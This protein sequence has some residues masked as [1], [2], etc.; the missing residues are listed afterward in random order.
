MDTLRFLTNMDDEYTNEVDDED[1]NME[2]NDDVVDEEEDVNIGIN[3][4]NSFL[5]GNNGNY[6]SDDNCDK[7]T[8]GNNL[9]NIHEQDFVSA[10]LHRK[11]PCR[12]VILSLFC[13]VLLKQ[14][15]DSKQTLF[16]CKEYRCL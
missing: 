3:L 9:N 6:D 16:I 5:N 1:D 7:N 13:Y 8:N 2:D 4:A 11:D 14:Q 12:Q 10:V 15:I